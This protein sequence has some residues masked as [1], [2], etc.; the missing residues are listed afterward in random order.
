MDVDQP[1][2][3]VLILASSKCMPDPAILSQLS[4][5]VKFYGPGACV[6]DFKELSEGEWKAID[7]V[8][9]FG[10]V[11]FTKV[12]HVLGLSLFPLCASFSCGQKCLFCWIAD[13]CFD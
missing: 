8:V 12:R 3:R 4:S 2:L 7:V 10:F 6:D 9:V 5:A 13:Q 11:P 1:H